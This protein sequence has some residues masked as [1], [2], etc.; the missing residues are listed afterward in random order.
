[1][2]IEENLSQNQDRPSTS[3]LVAAYEQLCATHHALDDFKMKLLGLLPIASVVGLFSLAATNSGPSAAV[4]Q[5]NQ[6]ILY[7]GVF[8][9]AFT[10]GLFI[11]ELRSILM[12][13]DLIVQGRSIEALMGVQGQFC[14][15]A[16]E[17]RT[18]QYRT[19]WKYVLA[20]HLNG[21]LASSSIYSLVFAAWLFVALRYGIGFHTL[22]CALCATGVGLVL[23][24]GSYSIVLS[25]LNAG[26]E[27]ARSA[28]TVPQA[29]T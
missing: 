21:K 10:L 4:V 27:A 20:H 26:S 28:R 2:P 3:V 9:A 8:A 18:S 16:E 5:P 19:R 25:L 14:V 29:V 24:V 13:H 1:M 12:C 7:V 15:C 22:T 23:S 6:I 11:Y 17:R